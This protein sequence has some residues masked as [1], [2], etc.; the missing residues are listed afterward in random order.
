MNKKTSKIIVYVLSPDQV[1]EE[2]TRF[3]TATIPVEIIVSPW[4]CKKQFTTRWVQY[5]REGKD[6]KPQFSDLEFNK[7]VRFLVNLALE[8]DKAEGFHLSYD[9]WKGEQVKDVVEF[10]RKFHGVTFNN[11]WDI[12]SLGERVIPKDIFWYTK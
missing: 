12:Q 4:V 1:A 8:L 2:R 7:I 11:R 5:I 3:K 6:I 10:L 9:I